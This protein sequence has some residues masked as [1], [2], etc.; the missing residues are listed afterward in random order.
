M[1]K[2]INLTFTDEEYAALTDEYKTFI[3]D[4]DF[5]DAV[6]P[7]LTG[8]CAAVIIC[9]LKINESSQKEKH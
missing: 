8:Y 3:R 6:P 7:T 1:S 5:T 4:Y 9:A 2:R